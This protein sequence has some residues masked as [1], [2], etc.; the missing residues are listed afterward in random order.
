MSTGCFE[1][2]GAKASWSSRPRLAGV[3]GKSETM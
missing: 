3:S 2:H 1:A